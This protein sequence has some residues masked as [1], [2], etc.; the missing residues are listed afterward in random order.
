MQSNT[1]EQ[2]I[3]DS[4]SVLQIIDE[5]LSA[6]DPYNC[7]F[8]VDAVRLADCQFPDEILDP[9]A[10]LRVVLGE[11]QTQ[12]LEY[13][14]DLELIADLLGDCVRRVRGTEAANAQ[15]THS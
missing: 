11:E 12:H 9:L 5:A 15:L 13:L 2:L 7:D 6:N 8:P 3:D 10:L 1:M 14:D 4:L